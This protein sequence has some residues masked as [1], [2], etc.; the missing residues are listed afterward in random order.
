M[1]SF[2]TAIAPWSAFLVLV[3]I[4]PGVTTA[5]TTTAATCSDTLTPSYAAPS[6]APGYEARLVAN[7]LYKPRGIIFDT[8]GNLLVVQQGGGIA[9]LR[10]S[11]GGGA[12]LSVA[13]NATVVKNANVSRTHLLPERCRLL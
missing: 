1:L 13:A 6:V 8:N 5:Q 7:G 9:G 4:L 3:A 10:L 2:S 12:C 11:D